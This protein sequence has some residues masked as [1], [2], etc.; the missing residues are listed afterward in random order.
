[1]TFSVAAR[2]GVLRRELQRAVVDLEGEDFLADT[3]YI[4]D[5]PERTTE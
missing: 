5:E 3:A 1:M 2:W 4:P